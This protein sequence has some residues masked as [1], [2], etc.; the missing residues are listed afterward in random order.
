[1]LVRVYWCAGYSNVISFVARC[2]KLQKDI[3]LFFFIE[4]HPQRLEWSG[5]KMNT[6]E[7]ASLQSITNMWTALEQIDETLQEGPIQK[8]DLRQHPGLTEFLE[9]CCQEKTYSFRYSFKY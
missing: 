4:F 9:H 2:S 6:F 5:K 1:M 3:N 8:K 7:S